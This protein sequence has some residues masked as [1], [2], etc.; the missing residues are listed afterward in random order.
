MNTVNDSMVAVKGDGQI[1]VLNHRAV[2]SREEALR[3]AAW[4]VALA[5]EDNDFDRLLEAVKAT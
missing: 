4:L 2:M 5:D 3:L 1:V